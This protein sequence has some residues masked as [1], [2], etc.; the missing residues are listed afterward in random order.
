MTVQ[1]QVR[2]KEKIYVREELRGAIKKYL[3]QFTHYMLYELC[4]INNK[5]SKCG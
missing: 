4:E 3:Y 5:N 2:G 1:T